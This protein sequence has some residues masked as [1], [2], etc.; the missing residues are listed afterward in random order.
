[1]SKVMRRAE[2][3]A[4]TNDLRCGD[5]LM[6][7]ATRYGYSYSHIS[8]CSVARRLMDY[9]DLDGLNEAYRNNSISATIYDYAKDELYKR[10]DE[11]KQIAKMK[12]EEEHRTNLEN[13]AAVCAAPAQW[14]GMQTNLIPELSM[15]FKTIAAALDNLAQTYHREGGEQ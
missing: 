6:E 1:M 4:V 5:N 15:I 13:A 12:A 8:K 9:G 10:V 14:I 11:A 2:F 3:I 7:V